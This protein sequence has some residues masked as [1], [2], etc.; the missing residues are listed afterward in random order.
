MANYIVTDTELTSIANAIRAKG[1][2]S[3]SLVFPSG[4]VSAIEN[5]SG[6]GLPDAYQEVDYL[7]STGTQYIDTGLTG[8]IDTE[9]IV[10]FSDFDRNG[11]NYAGPFG[12]AATGA[13]VIVVCGGQVR[14]YTSFGNKQDVYYNT[15]TASA[16]E[17][18]TSTKR[19][20]SISKNGVYEDDTQK[21]AAYD[22]PTYSSSNLTMVIFARKESDGTVGT[23]IGTKIYSFVC[24]KNGTE[25][26]HFVPCYRKSDNEPGMYDTVSGEFFTNDGTG[27]FT[28]P[29]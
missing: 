28:I 29:S 18:A 9:W 14:V 11:N 8:D 23:M 2:T 22:N 5:I 12:I 20:I 3:G 26:A 4:F 21:L 13:K 15:A 7:Q 1:G 16:T 6:G 17:W 27:S 24:K 19:K 10:E 25:L